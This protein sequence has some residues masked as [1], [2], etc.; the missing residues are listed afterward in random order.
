MDPLTLI[1]TA[2]V[3]GASAGL[4]GTATDFIKDTYAGLKQLVV[5]RFPHAKAAVED[6]DNNPTDEESKKLVER[7]LGKLD[8]TQVTEIV[9]QAEHLLQA[10]QQVAPQMEIFGVK[11]KDVE[12][13]GSAT[14]DTITSA[15]TGVSAEK[16]TV[17]GDFTAKNIQAGQTGTPRPNA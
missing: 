12:I 13:G 16:T 2:L 15:Q 1:V 8:A 3:A 4:Q 11:L 9:Q 10:V 17:H 7:R 14:F 5:S 6:M